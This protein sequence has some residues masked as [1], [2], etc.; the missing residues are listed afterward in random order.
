LLL[1]AH[2]TLIDL[3]DFDRIKMSELMSDDNDETVI[4]A[5]AMRI[6]LDVH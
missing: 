5:S 3:F 2:G 1:S 4:L 6:F